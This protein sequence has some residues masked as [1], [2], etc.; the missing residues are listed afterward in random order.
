V[1]DTST[2]ASLSTASATNTITVTTTV[3]QTATTTYWLTAANET[4]TSLLDGIWST[5]STT[6]TAGSIGTVGTVHPSSWFTGTGTGTGVLGTGTG[7][8]TIRPSAGASNASLTYTVPAVTTTQPF[9]VVSDGTRGHHDGDG[10]IGVYYVVMAV[11][12]AV[13]LLVG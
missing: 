6:G 13:A 5:S 4:T 7:T 12:C 8:G 10:K 3:S 1:S 11:V 2:S 9:T